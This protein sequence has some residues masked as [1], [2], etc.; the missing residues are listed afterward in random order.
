[1][2]KPKFIAALLANFVMGALFAQQGFSDWEKSYFKKNSSDEQIAFI[3]KLKLPDELAFPKIIFEKN[4]IVDS[5]YSWCS[6]LK[7]SFA[8]FFTEAKSYKYNKKVALAYGILNLGNYDVFKYHE[9]LKK[10]INDTLWVEKTFNTLLP[11]LKESWYLLDNNTR[12]IYKSI[13]KHTENYLGSFNYEEERTYKNQLIVLSKP[14]DFIVKSRNSNIKNDFRK[15]EAFIFRRMN[16]S[17][18]RKGNWSIY[19]ARKM[20][21]KIKRSLVI[22]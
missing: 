4:V 18:E 10:C 11:V 9:G 17:N 21:L 3:K 15:A 2:I 7:R 19:W 20:L 22:A 6:Y 5:R 12:D 8:A 16:D 13:I 14:D 1:M